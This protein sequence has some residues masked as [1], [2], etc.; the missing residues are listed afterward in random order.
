MDEI[1]LQGL[2]FIKV[3][4]ALEP[5]RE[6]PVHPPRTP[7]IIAA[8]DAQAD[9]WPSG[10][11]LLLDPSSGM[12]YGEY[13]VFKQAFLSLVGFPPEKLVRGNPIA[14]CE[15]AAV[16]VMM[17]SCGP[18]LSGRDVVALHRQH[19]SDA[20]LR[21]RHLH[22]RRFDEDRSSGAL[23]QLPVQAQSLV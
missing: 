10:G 20:L 18:W 22:E 14:Q 6:A 16:V 5:R 11:F 13:F 15:A 8:S 12:K 19:L 2:D 23:T 21:E 3:L 9:S 4:L 1:L 17:I 7:H